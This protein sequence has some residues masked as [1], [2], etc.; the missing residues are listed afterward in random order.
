MV[1]LSL[2]I[3]RTLKPSLPKSMREKNDIYP[4]RAVLLN[5]TLLSPGGDHLEVG[6]GEAE[7]D[8]TP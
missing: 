5:A 3:G 4:D 6:F 8:V 7:C 1:P 2:R